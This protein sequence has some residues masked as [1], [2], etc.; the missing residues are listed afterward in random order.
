MRLEDLKSERETLKK[1]LRDIDT[2]HR[3]VEIQLKLLRQNEIRTKR[4]IEALTT[5]IEINE[6]RNEAPKQADPEPAEKKEQPS[7]AT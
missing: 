2:D 7:T 5:L 4:E 1:R 6:S 3:K